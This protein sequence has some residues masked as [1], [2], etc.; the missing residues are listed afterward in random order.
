VLHRLKVYHAQTAAIIEHYTK[1]GVV[2]TFRGTESNE[3]YPRMQA[4]VEGFHRGIRHKHR[5]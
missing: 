5:S 4:Y 3:I 2:Q 1:Q